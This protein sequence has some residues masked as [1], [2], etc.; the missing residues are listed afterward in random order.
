MDQAPEYPTRVER[1]NGEAEYGTI[2]QVTN[3]GALETWVKE[4]FEFKY[5]VFNA[6]G[7]QIKDR[8]FGKVKRAHFKFR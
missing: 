2:I 3:L 1:V 5:I 8:G 6:S 4:K 7:T